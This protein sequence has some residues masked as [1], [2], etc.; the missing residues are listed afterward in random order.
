[1]DKNK[2]ILLVDCEYK[3]TGRGTLVADKEVSWQI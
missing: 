1:M 2:M 3:D